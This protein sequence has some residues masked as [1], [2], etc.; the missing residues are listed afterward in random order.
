MIYLIE[1]TVTHHLKIGFSNNVKKRLATLNTSSPHRLI[2]LGTIEGSMQDEKELQKRFDFCR[3]NGEWF[4]FKNQIINYFAIIGGQTPIPQALETYDKY[5]AIRNDLYL[6]T[7][8]ETERL[9][10]F[11]KLKTKTKI[12]TF[13][14]LFV[15]FKLYLFSNFSITFIL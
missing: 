15:A 6:S 11:A 5:H 1:N 8:H 14:L 13:S 10:I 7:L 12:K 9:L 4:E 2:L 3:V